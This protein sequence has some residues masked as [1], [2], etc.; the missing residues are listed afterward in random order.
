[1]SGNGS[2]NECARTVD[3]SVERAFG[4]WDMET[5]VRLL[6]GVNVEVVVPMDPHALRH[7]DAVTTQ[8]AVE[9]GRFD[10]CV[11]RGIGDL[12]LAALS[13]VQG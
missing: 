1:L 10:A 11:G 5:M 9:P 2:G 12:R 3:A 8:L 6:T 4:G 13:E 7:W